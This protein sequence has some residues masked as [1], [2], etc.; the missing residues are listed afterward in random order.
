MKGLSARMPLR[1]RLVLLTLVLV[2]LALAVSAV[3]ATYALHDYLIGRVD[4]QLAQ[5]A[6][7]Y[8][9]RDCVWQ[10]DGY[11]RRS[12]G[13]VGAYFAQCYSFDGTPTAINDKD[14]LRGESPPTLPTMNRQ[15]LHD[16]IDDPMFLTGPDGTTWRAVFAI[17]QPRNPPQVQDAPQ[18][19]LKAGPAPVLLAVSLE[20]TDGIVGKQIALE[21]IIGGVVLAMLAVIAY[22]LVRSSLRPLVTVERTA[23]AIAAGDLTRRVP[24]AD[25]RTE[26]GGL[27][28]ALNTMLGQIETAFD[29]RRQSEEAAR[30][31]EAR[32]RRFIA[33]AS[34]ELR[35]PLTSIRGFAELYRQHG[36]DDPDVNRIISRIEHHATRMGVL[37]E[38]LL[39]LARLDQQRPLEHRPVD[40]MSLATDAVIDARV[41]AP[42]HTVR[43]RTGGDADSDDYDVEPPAVLG[44]EVRLRQVIGN[45]VANAVTHTPAG[46]E[47]TVYVRT[48][49]REAVLEVADNGPG[50][51][52]EDASRVFERF[53]RTDPSR[54]RAHGGSGLG[55]SIVAALVHAHGGEVSVRTAEGWGAV[56]S[57]RLPLIEA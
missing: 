38:D 27:S 34:H 20:E 52:A 35:T 49:G 48:E 39:L 54:T 33:D 53:Y 26:V 47:V 3:A 10:S 15:S 21:F 44:D 36:V 6:R 9:A 18:P 12:M 43:L 24:E 55:L 50:M 17:T 29:E 13:P 57:V 41:T 42:G 28:Q 2:A 56:F 5:S 32:M 8:N 19:T 14:G 11:G 37:V 31:S 4:A 51:S 1:V 16:A 45:L 7:D 22:V 23:E 30:S 40:L 25:P 46:T